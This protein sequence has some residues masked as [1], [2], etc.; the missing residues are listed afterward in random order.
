MCV[1]AQK[2]K[3]QKHPIGLVN[4]VEILS[5]AN[6]ACNNEIKALKAFCVI[7]ERP[8]RPV[9]IQFSEKKSD[10]HNC[11]YKRFSIVYFKN[12]LKFLEQLIECRTK[13]AFG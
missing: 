9:K 8:S 7:S 3:Q 10:V 2:E 5:Q 12:K 4:Y 6:R 1:C 11:T 13:L